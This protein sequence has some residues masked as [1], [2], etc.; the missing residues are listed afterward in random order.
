M[1]FVK[2]TYIL[3]GD[4]VLALT[5]Y[6][7]LDALYRSIS[8]QHY[9][10]VSAMATQLSRGSSVHE[11]QLILYAKESVKPAYEYFKKKFDHDLQHLVKAFK[12]AHIF[13]PSR[14]QPTTDI[15]YYCGERSKI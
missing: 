1:P 8:L 4:G 5:A 14:I 3:E 6:G 13:S 10:N 9:P 12:A 11:Q 7:Q 2:A 15:D